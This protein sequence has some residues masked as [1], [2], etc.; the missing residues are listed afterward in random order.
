[1]HSARKPNA[2]KAP[3]S[4][5][6]IGRVGRT[7]TLAPYTE[8]ILEA[9]ARATGIPR[10]RIVDLALRSLVLCPACEG[11]GTEDGPLGAGTARCAVC[12]GDKIIPSEH[13][14]A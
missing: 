5:T 13:E 3:E 12:G 1:M 11:M 8:A 9:W 2:P 6:R 7:L 10:G 14:H 4:R